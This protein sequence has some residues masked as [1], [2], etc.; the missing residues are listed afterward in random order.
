MKSIKPGDMIIPSP[1]DGLGRNP[2]LV[3]EV[4]AFHNITSLYIMAN[5]GTTSH[6]L[7]GV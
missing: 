6:P 1:Y 5:N 3:L 7:K 2:F 4:H